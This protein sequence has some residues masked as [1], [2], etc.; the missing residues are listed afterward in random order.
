MKDYSN[1]IRLYRIAGHTIKNNSKNQWKIHIIKNEFLNIMNSYDIDINVKEPQHQKGNY[2]EQSHLL[3]TALRH[4]NLWLSDLIIKNYRDELKFGTNDK[5]V[6]LLLLSAK[7]HEFNTFKYFYDKYIKFILHSPLA[8]KHF[9]VEDNTFNLNFELSEPVKDFKRTLLHYSM[10]NNSC[11][12]YDFL[13][14]EFEHDHVSLNR[15]LY[16]NTIL[17]VSNWF[18]EQ[19]YNDINNSNT[20]KIYLGAN[21]YFHS[22]L[23]KY[24]TKVLKSLLDKELLTEKQISNILKSTIDN[25]SLISFNPRTN[26]SNLV[27]INNNFGNNK[28]I[29]TSVINTLFS[30]RYDKPFNNKQLSFIKTI[31]DVHMNN[32]E[33]IECCM[34]KEGTPFIKEQAISWKEYEFL[35]KDRII[36]LDELSRPLS[37]I[38]KNK[39]LRIDAILNLCNIHHNI[40]SLNKDFDITIN[41]MKDKLF[42]YKD[43]FKYIDSGICKSK[44]SKYA[45]PL[46]KLIDLDSLNNNHNEFISFYGNKN[47]LNSLYYKSNNNDCLDSITSYLKDIAFI[48]PFMLFVGEKELQKTI[49]NKT[50]NHDNILK[51]LMIIKHIT[52]LKNEGNMNSDFLKLKEY[53]SILINDITTLSDRLSLSKASVQYLDEDL[54]GL[55]ICSKNNKEKVSFLFDNYDRFFEKHY[56]NQ[57]IT[58]NNKNIFT[59]KKRI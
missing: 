9:Y 59:A 39:F 33:I 40:L 44:V 49:L 37:H 8:N 3:L 30:K 24:N 41:D 20:D 6:P 31:T 32:K 34:L 52:H 22:G 25:S 23:N 35:V 56:L 13:I 4:N 36:H 57:N 48:S 17:P 27:E 42:F 45:T 29:M 51:E 55:F 43:E 5:Q 28:N 47:I 7:S 58:L 18:I 19:Y 53:F 2:D 38:K 54:S 46:L 10:R 16:Q 12:I 21:V 1:I 11:D 14:N 15:S 50:I 26:Y